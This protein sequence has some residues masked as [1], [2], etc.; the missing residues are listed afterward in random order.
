LDELFDDEFEL[1]LLDE[2]ELEL[3]ELFDDEFELELLE[4]FEL[5]LLDEFDEL[6]PATMIAPSLWLVTMLAGRSA[7]IDGAAYGFACAAVPATAAI[8]ATRADANILELIMDLLL[9]IGPGVARRSNGRGPT[10]FHAKKA[11]TQRRL[12]R[13]D[14][15]QQRS[16]LG[17]LHRRLGIDGSQIGVERFGR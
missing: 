12:F 1:E 10:L 7:S 11:R 15:A 17:G 14:G 6:L 13:G 16:L 2:F 8:P 9:C 4:E 5:E 3:D